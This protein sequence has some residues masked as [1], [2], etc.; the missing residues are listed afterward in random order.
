DEEALD[1]L[2]ENKKK[3][4][5]APGLAWLI[6][7]CHNASAYGITPQVA[8]GM[9]YFRELEAAIETMKA[10]RRRDVR[11]L[12]GGD[13][14]FAWTPHGTNAKDLE[15]FVQHVGM[16]TMEAL[17]SAT[18]WGAPMMKMKGQVGEIREGCLADILLVDGDPLEDI[19]VL[20]DKR[21]I[22][23]VMKDGAFHRAPPLRT[24]ARTEMT[25][26]AA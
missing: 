16:S 26:W 15:Y 25:R 17:L 10:L 1:L 21:R 6:N 22:L 14:G 18:A 3:H 13:Y 24:G 7:T 11:I 9:G 23:A 19:A 20:Q 4:F 12:P 2:E 8:R 5:I